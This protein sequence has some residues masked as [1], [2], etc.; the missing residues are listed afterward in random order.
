MQKYGKEKKITE[1]NEKYRFGDKQYKNNIN[2]M[3]D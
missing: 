1:F 3:N 2:E